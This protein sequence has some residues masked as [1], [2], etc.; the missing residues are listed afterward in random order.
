MTFDVTL[1]GDSILNRRVSDVPD[2]RFGRLVSELRDADV[3]YTHLETLIHDYHGP[4]VYP[5]AEAGWTWMRS[6]RE[7]ASELRWLGIDLVSTASNHALDYGVGGLRSTWE[8]LD[9]AGI[10]HAGTGEDLGAARSPVLLDRRGRRVALVSMTTSLTRSARAGGSR[11]D[12]RGRPGANPLS[13]TYEVDPA[14]F[15]LV[16]TL[17]HRTGRWVERVSATDWLVNPPGLHNSW[18]R[19]RVSEDVVGA[20]MV[21][22]ERDLA[23]N[24][25]SIEDACGRADLVVVHIHNHEWDPDLGLDTPPGFVRVIA[26]RAIDVGAQVVIAEGSHAPL[27]GAELRGD[28]VILYDP[29]DLFLMSASVTRFPL[30]FYE[31]H[32]DRLEGPPEEATLS[33]AWAAREGHD[34][35][36]PP[37]GYRN[38]PVNGGVVVRCRFGDDTRLQGVELLPFDW[39][40]LPGEHGKLPRRA[41]ER[42]ATAIL[43]R[44]DELS[45]PFGTRVERWDALGVLRPCDREAVD[46]DSSVA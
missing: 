3:S 18:T 28:G 19:Y 41:G 34:V 6:P 22:D 12:V 2:A 32:R 46:T 27:R 16:R 10:A 39:E 26:Q 1:S 23:G 13:Y 9:G 29:G 20:R 15:E 45:R 35:E 36:N 14:T 21:A 17:A 40:L 31:R 5:S 4:E 8:S 30:D 7:T 24:L 11:Q 37:G 33:A 44:L 42:T 38:H 43:E 25:T